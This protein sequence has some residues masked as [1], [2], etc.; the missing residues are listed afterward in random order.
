MDSTSQ[1]E[2][3]NWVP[4][5]WDGGGRL[6][7]GPGLTIHVPGALLRRYGYRAIMRLASARMGRHMERLQVAPRLG[8]RPH[9]PAR[10]PR[11]ARRVR[12]RRTV[13]VDADDGPPG[14]GDRTRRGAS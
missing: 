2:T 12:V 14:P 7:V 10:T 6:L 11:R 13:R 5:D 8:H 3:R 1:K 9:A 4:P